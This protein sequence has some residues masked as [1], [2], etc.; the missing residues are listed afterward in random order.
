MSNKGKKLKKPL[1]INMSF[2]DAMKKISN[3]KK[4]DIDNNIGKNK[5]SKN[6]S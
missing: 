2:N 5:I 6:K 1:Q 4:S 3:V